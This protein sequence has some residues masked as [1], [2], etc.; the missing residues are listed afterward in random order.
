MLQELK[1][2]FAQQAE[3]ELLQAVRDF[4]SCKQEEGQSEFDSFMQ[5]YN[6]HSMGK[7]V[8][9]K[10][11]N[12]QKKPQL[13]AR[14]Q[15]QRKGKS[16]LAYTPKPKIPPSS[17]R[18]NLAKDSICHQCGDTVSRL[19]DDGYLNCFVDNAISISRNN[20]VYFSAVPRDGIFEIDLSNSNTIDSS[21]YVV[22]NKRTKLNLDFALL[23]HCPLGHISKKRIE[24]LQHDGLLNST[25]LRAFEK[26]VSCMCG[27]M[28]RKPYT[29][30]VKRA[31]DL[32]GLIHTDEVENQLSKTIKSLRSD[33]GGEYMSQEFLDN[34]KKHGIIAHRTP[35]YTPQHNDRMCLYIDAEEHEL[36]D[37]GELANYKAVLLDP[38]SDKW[39]N[40]M[41][42]VD[43]QKKTDT[44]G[45]VHTFKACI[46][47]KGFTQT[48]GVDYKETFFPVADIRAIRIL[49]VIAAYYDYEIWQMDVKTVF[50]NG[51][52]SEEFYMEQP[53][54]FVNPKYPNLVCKRKCFIYGLKQASRQWNKR[55]DDEIN[56]FGF[57]QNRD[58]PCV[59][60]KASG[61]NVTFLILCFAMKDLG[62]AA[63][64]L[65]IKIY[66]DRS[67]RLI[68]LCQSAYI[69][70][71]LKRFPMENSKCGSIP[72]VSCYTDAE[73]LMDADDLKS[74][75][76]YVFV[77]NGDVVDWKS[78]KQS[79]FVTSSAEAEYIATCDASKE[80][81]WV[82]KLIF[83][84]GVVP[85]IETHKYVQRIE[86]KA[87]TV[88]SLVRG[89]DFGSRL[90]KGL[91]EARD[92]L[93]YPSQH[94][95][96]WYTTWHNATGGSGINCAGGYE[97]PYPEG[98]HIYPCH[99]SYA[100]MNTHHRRK[101]K[102]CR[103][104]KTLPNHHSILDVLELSDIPPA[105]AEIVSPLDVNVLHEVPRI[106]TSTLLAVPVS[107]TPSPLTTTETTNIPPST[108][109]FASVFRFNDRVIALE[110]DVAEL[111]NDPLHT[112][113]TAL[114]NDHL[115]TRMGA[116]R[117]EFMSFLSTSLTNKLT[118]QVRNQLPLIL[119]EE[120]SNFAPP[121]IKKM[122]QESLNQVNLAK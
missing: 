94:I 108:P 51:H 40:A 59:Y 52:L 63:Y 45:V 60:L 68:G 104:Y 27:K 6:I 106:H 57:T 54:G 46:V 3:Q 29:H 17:K 28:A 84:L 105:D 99:L 2:L 97:E 93:G 116:T 38:E 9:E 21:M 89:R 119:P 43:L 85:T 19:Y 86:N 4:H 12:K 66:R 92:W 100:S 95:Y 18:E 30:Q 56:K 98:L 39:L 20:L 79:I 36:G 35:P 109:D 76:G 69:E 114:V 8:N 42:Q 32:L 120:V 10:K 15:N 1:T 73:Y 103:D 88:W 49:I 117:E 118:K 47:A 113:V 64:I 48:Y 81:V 41:N 7:T 74:Q 25:D 34:L 91:E 24:K 67:R 71:I 14:G 22:S 112:Q 90:G 72:I 23:W 111:K 11:Y 87:K 121:V 122:I 75:T 78:T 115:D 83:G 58:E 37:L 61:S 62:E 44:D 80:A 33:R 110:K 102:P 5:N 107:S 53:E 77:L 26:C 55:F 96:R 65:G 70:K 82:R 50:L 16:K 31:K 101:R 13:A